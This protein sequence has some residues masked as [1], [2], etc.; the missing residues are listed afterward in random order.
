MVAVA[1]YFAQA[2]VALRAAAIILFVFLTAPVAAHVIARAAY[3]TGGGQ[4]FRRTVVDELAGRCDQEAHKLRSEV[5]EK[6]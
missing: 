1:L 4:L 2:G 6:T 5:L 3:S